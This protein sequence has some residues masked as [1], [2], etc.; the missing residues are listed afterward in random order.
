MSSP[1]ANAVSVN[2]IIKA[3]KGRTAGVDDNSWLVSFPTEG[4]SDNAKHLI[5]MLKGWSAKIHPTAKNTIK[6][7]PP[8]S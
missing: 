2:H 6:I 5:V 7:F 4:D 1:K 3:F 8:N